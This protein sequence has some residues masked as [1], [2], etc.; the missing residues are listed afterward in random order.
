MDLIN[1]HVDVALAVTERTAE[2]YEDYA[3]RPERIRS[4][5]IGSDAARF[6]APSGNP[7]TRSPGDLMRLVYLGESRREKGFHFLLHEL[8]QL[9]ADALRSLDLTI[10]CRV[11]DQAELRMAAEHRGLLLSLAEALGRFTYRPGYSREDLPGIL[12][13]VH[14]GIVPALWEDNLP[15]VTLELLACRVPVLCSDRGGAQEFVRHPAFI[16]DPDKAGDFRSRLSDL[17]QVPTLLDDFW[18]AARMPRTMDQHFAELVGVYKD[19]SP[20]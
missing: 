15:Q 1:R 17:Q 9:P 16:Y 13:G 19:P 4:L 11:T 14:L 8:R 18:R 2:I 20:S 12:Q 7:A 3:V 6:Q 10:A 5:Y